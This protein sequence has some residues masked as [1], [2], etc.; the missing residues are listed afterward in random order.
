MAAE[1]ALVDLAV[2]EA[3]EGHAVVLKFDHD[4]VGF[5]AHEFDRILV[6]KP[7]G[8]LDGVVHVPVP[9]IFLGVA[10]AGSDAALRRDGV[11]TGGKDLGQHGGPEAGLGQLNGGTQAGTTGTDNHCIKLANGI[12]HCYSLQMI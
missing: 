5:A 12:R 7:V 10:Q 4:F 1:G 3:V 9:V 2:I 8:T 6:A 11:R